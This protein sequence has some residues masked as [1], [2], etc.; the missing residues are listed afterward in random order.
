MAILNFTG[1]ESGSTDESASTGGGSLSI[2]TSIKRS[3]T[4]SLR[5]SPTTTNTGYV[6]LR[7]HGADGN[8]N[9]DLN[10]ATAYYRTYLYM[11]TIPASGSEQIFLV[12]GTGSTNKFSVRINSTGVLSIYNSTGSQI[13]SNGTTV[14]STST[15][16]RIELL[17]ATGNPASYELRINGVTEFSGTA[18]MGVA[19]NAGIRLGKTQNVSSQTVDFYYDDVAISD[20][21]WLG[22]S[23]VSIL[24]PNANGSTMQWTA[25]TGSSNYLEVDE[26][27][28]DT[29]THVQ[30]TGGT[31]EIA[32]FAMENS[33]VQ[34]ISGTI[35]AV[36]ALIGARESVSTTSSV[37]L[38][39]RSGGVDSDTTGLDVATTNTSLARVYET[40]PADSASWTTSKIDGLEVG[41]VEAG[42]AIVRL[43]SVVL[44]VLWQD[45]GTPARTSDFMS[46]FH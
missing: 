16:Y 41:A 13:G 19:N 24:V 31:G 5:V 4:Y 10:V 28:R 29:T 14:L 18:N 32:L 23:K 30:N 46:F 40:D 26:I 43:T 42:T 25:G 2:Q 9:A 44:M 21:G 20:S 15:W 1:F 45:S 22:D 27:P 11:A 3:G 38:R 35:Y 7:G 17:C 37:K 39:V 8:L 12:R 36:K 33:S 6:E 34:S